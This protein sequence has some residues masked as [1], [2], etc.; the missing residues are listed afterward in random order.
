VWE[1]NTEP[2]TPPIASP[3]NL[4]AT[5][6]DAKVNLSWNAVS[7]AHSY[8]LKRTVIPGGTYITIATNISSTSYVDRTVTNG[9]TYYYIVTAIDG[10]GKESANSNEASATPVAAQVPNRQVLLRVTMIDSSE[11]E[12]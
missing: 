12:Y 5:A 9:T 1:G 11:W 2:S 6:G 7:G 8:N 10:N 3:T 4:I